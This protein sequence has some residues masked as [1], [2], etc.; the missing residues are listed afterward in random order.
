MQK[1]FSQ[2]IRFRRDDGEEFGKWEERRLGE[3]GETINGLTGKT[4]DDFGVGK[5][6]I[7][8]KQIFDSSKIN[9]NDCGL[10]DIKENENQNRVQYGDVFFTTS[11]ET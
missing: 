4:K 6:Y 8:Y 11:S 1:I 10:I 3:I 9:I 2:E 7:Q 5:P